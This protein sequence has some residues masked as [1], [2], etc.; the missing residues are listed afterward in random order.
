MQYVTFT[1]VTA[2]YDAFGA[3]KRARDSLRACGKQEAAAVFR[4]VTPHG[5]ASQDDDLVENTP[6][7]K[8]PAKVDLETLKNLDAG[9][10]SLNRWKQSLLAGSAPA[11]AGGDP[12]NVIVEKL[13]FVSDGR[14]DIV[15]DL[16]GTPRLLVSDRFDVGCLIELKR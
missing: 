14:T 9:D 3:D 2:H 4:S 12:R 10:E 15:L 13:I 16:T 6:G 7:Y 1:R 8:P 11:A 5:R